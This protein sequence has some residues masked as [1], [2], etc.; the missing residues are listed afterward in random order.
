MKLTLREL[1]DQLRV[2]ESPAWPQQPTNVESVNAG[3]MGVEVET[4]NFISVAQLREELR[5]AEQE[6]ED[7]EEE[8][9][10]REQKIEV[11]EANI[12]KIKDAIA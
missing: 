4:T 9:E 3:A 1:I 10:R 12:A 7:L 11:L 2:L 6:L 5:Q 8:M